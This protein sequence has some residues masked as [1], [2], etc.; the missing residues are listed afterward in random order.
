MKLDARPMLVWSFLVCLI[1]DPVGSGR[2]RA[3]APPTEQLF[4]IGVARVDITP[5]YPI[6]LTGFVARK[7]ESDSLGLRLWAKALA[8][9]GDPEGPAILITVDNCGVGENVTGEVA[10]RL[11]RKAGIPRERIAVASSHTHSGPQT[12]G[13]AANIFAMDLPEAQNRAIASYT[14]ELTDKLEEVALT[15]LRARQPAH[16]FHS[17]G[18]VDFAANRRTPG[19]P[20]DHSL[21]VLCVRDLGGTVRAIVANY[22]CHCT[23]VGSGFNQTCGD[24]AGFAGERLE[25]LF[26]QAL[27][28]VTIGCGADSNPQPRGGPDAGL[29]LAKDHGTKLAHE[30]S[31]VINRPMKRLNAQPRSDAKQIELPFQKHFTREQWEERAKK[32]G[33]VGYHAKKHLARLDRGELLPSAL[34]YLVQ[35]WKFGDQLAMVFLNGEVVVDYAL[36]MKRELDATRL[37]ITAY[38]NNVPC[39]IPSRRILQEGGYEAEESLWYYDLPQR[40]ALE[41]E[42]LIVSSVHELLGKEFQ[43]PAR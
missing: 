43:P 1:L 5:D 12:I 31:A 32:D 11:R 26:P 23:T 38:A 24:W 7:T 27:A 15:A 39:Y 42:E 3:A 40:L 29:Q 6:R 35:T 13:F 9:G 34:P 37:W 16:L 19:G 33:I 2:L 4:Q 10:T 36:R 20:V 22:A 41:T 30:A 28:L 14:K 25:S 8:I 18:R 21:P 17:E